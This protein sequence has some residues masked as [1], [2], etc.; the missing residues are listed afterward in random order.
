M[1]FPF[2][3]LFI[4]HKAAHIAQNYM[5]SLKRNFREFTVASEREDM[6]AGLSQTSHAGPAAQPLPWNLLQGLRLH[7][8]RTGMS[9][10]FSPEPVPQ[11]ESVQPSHG[12]GVL[13]A[14]GDAIP[15]PMSA[16]S[17]GR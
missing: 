14:L 11:A 2:L 5:F 4:L 16:Y 8:L 9:N 7:L 6:Q 15:W 12:P 1:A 10:A 3:H 17:P 13:A